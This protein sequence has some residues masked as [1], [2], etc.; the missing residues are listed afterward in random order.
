MRITGENSVDNSTSINTVDFTY[1]LLSCRSSAEDYEITFSGVVKREG[2]FKS[3]GFSA[4]TNR[5]DSVEFSGTVSDDY[6]TEVADSCSLSLSEQGSDY[7]DTEVSG[8]L[9]GRSVNF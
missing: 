8:K 1:E 5:S 3:S 6:P 7:G 9:C 4:V 2:T